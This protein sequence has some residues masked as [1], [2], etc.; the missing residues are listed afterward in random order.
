MVN[1]KKNQRESQQK[2]RNYRN[3]EEISL[4]DGTRCI[5]I[6]PTSAE[7]SNIET[8]E[9]SMNVNLDV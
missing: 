8:D 5:E 2:T 7:R 6:A 9:K 4:R 3:N 1:N